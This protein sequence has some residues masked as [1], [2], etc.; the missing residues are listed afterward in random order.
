MTDDERLD[1]AIERAAEILHRARYVVALTG[2]GIS[3]D[4]GIPPF[5]G[6]GGLWTKHGEPPMDGYQRFLADPRKAWEERLSPKGPLRELWETLR[7]ARP[8][9]GHYA[10]AELESMGVLR[11]LITQN[12]DNLHTEAGSREV[13]EIHGNYRLV[14]CIDCVRRFPR[15]A[16]SLDVLPPRCPECG[17]VL[18]SDTVSFGEPI[19]PDVLARCFEEAAQADCMLVAGTSATVYPAAQFPYDV[20]ARGGKLVEVN[21]YESELTPFCDVSL[22]GRSA[23]VLPKLVAKLR[24]LRSDSGPEPELLA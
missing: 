7:R 5:R 24:E 16:V 3:V 23:E 15:E 18:K 22:R 6:P 2:A 13:A 4:S 10:L 21:L 17:G 1:G 12:V 8:N 14:R 19:P 20:R 9:P 11:C